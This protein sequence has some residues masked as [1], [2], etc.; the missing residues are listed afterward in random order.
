MNSP[1]KLIPGNLYDFISPDKENFRLYSK[2]WKSQEETFDSFTIRNKT[3]YILMH[4]ATFIFL[5]SDW[6]THPDFPTYK[7]QYRLPIT[8][9]KILIND[10]IGFLPVNLE[11]F[12]SSIHEIS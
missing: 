12:F 6:I 1:L 9:I 2:S 3:D 7:I 5:S 8:M 11:I 10:K 4:K